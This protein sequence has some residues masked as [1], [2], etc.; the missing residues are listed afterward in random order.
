MEAI[1]SVKV[2][3]CILLCNKEKMWFHIF[4]T[5]LTNFV[6]QKET[7]DLQLS[8]DSAVWKRD[9]FWN[10]QITVSHLHC[11]WGCTPCRPSRLILA[12]YLWVL[13]ILKLI[14]FWLQ[15]HPWSS[16]EHSKPSSISYSYVL[17]NLGF[18]LEL[19]FSVEKLVRPG[20][21]ADRVED[22]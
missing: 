22:V 16:G 15:L 7:C 2:V 6:C 19:F 4:R 9:T 1:V 21:E 10:M 3:L 5:L 13:F 14:H 12:V 18:V 20:A 11:Q 17:S 8:C